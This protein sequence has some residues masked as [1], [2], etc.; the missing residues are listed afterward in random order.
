MQG[1]NWVNWGKDSRVGRLWGLQAEEGVADA[2]KKATSEVRPLLKS[3]QSKVSSIHPAKSGKLRLGNTSWGIVTR[4][5]KTE[6]KG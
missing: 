2:R 1:S 3:D 5:M 4:S 6:I